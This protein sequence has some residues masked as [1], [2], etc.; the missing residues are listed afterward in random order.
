MAATPRP[1]LRLTSG[2]ATTWSKVGDR[3]IYVSDLVDLATR[4]DAVL[5]VGY[6]RVAKGEEMEISFPYDEVLVVTRGSY[7]VRTG[8]GTEHRARAGEVIYLLAGS[9]NVA[10]ADEDTEMVYVAGPPD[11]YA[12]HVAGAT[13]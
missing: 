1:V 12:D 7:T 11:V 2:D 9:A 6:A 3:D 13:P 8:G 5:T 4:P 10:R